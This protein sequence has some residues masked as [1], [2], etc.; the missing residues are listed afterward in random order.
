MKDVVLRGG[1]EVPA[2]RITEQ[3]KGQIRQDIVYA[4]QVGQLTRRQ[5]VSFP[6]REEPTAKT[7]KSQSTGSYG[8]NGNRS[9]PPGGFISATASLV[10]P[11]NL[12]GRRIGI[13][14]VSGKRA[15]DK[16]GD[17]HR[18][19]ELTRVGHGQKTRP[20]GEDVAG[21]DWRRATCRSAT[22]AVR[23]DDDGNGGHGT[24]WDGV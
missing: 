15:R 11:G 4:R 20:S 12:Q 7:V 8:C 24:T 9:H 22:S 18:G 13:S 17:G 16:G 23:P 10:R 2:C 6:R 21:H 14:E 19:T 1:G 3:C 5:R